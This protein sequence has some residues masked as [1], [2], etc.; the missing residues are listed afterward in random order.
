MGGSFSCLKEK[1]VSDLSGFSRYEKSKRV[2]LTGKDMIAK[3]MLGGG[4]W[5]GG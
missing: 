2:W 3:A 5:G 1:L 4:G